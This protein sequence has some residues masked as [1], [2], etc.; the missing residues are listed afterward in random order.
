MKKDYILMEQGGAFW[1]YLMNLAA[2]AAKRRILKRNLN[3][4]FLAKVEGNSTETHE[5]ALG[6]WSL[7]A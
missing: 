6:W 4:R 5:W 7:W 2:E 3:M 1:Y